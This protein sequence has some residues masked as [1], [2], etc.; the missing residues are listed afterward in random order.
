[1]GN[2]VR[3]IFRGE[4]GQGIPFYYDNDAQ[5]PGVSFWFETER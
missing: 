5:I 2:T 3:Q 4:A 1:L